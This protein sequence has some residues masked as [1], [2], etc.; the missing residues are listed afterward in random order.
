MGERRLIEGAHGQLEVE[1]AGPADGVALLFHTGTPADG[2]IYASQVREGAERGLRHVAY[3]RPGYGRSARHADRSVADCV[4]DVV[5]IAD[6]LGIGRFFTAGLSGGGPHALACAAELSDRVIAAATL[7]GI[8]PFDA[9]GLDWWNGM[10]QENLDEMG[11]AAVGEAELRA[12]LDLEGAQLAAVT[13]PELNAAFGDLVSQ[14][15]RDALTGEFAEFMA[16]GVRE[17]LAPGVDGWLDDDLAFVRDWGFDLASIRVP[18]TVWQGE[19]D[20][21]VPL[22]H[23]AWLAANV[24]SAKARLEPDHGHLS[25]VLTAYGEI[26]DELIAAAD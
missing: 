14:P 12:Y 10:G 20:R 8:A 18:V 5:A 23:G 3:S 17:A 11:A 1:S 9:Q 13:G 2:T 26:L 25:L 4:T 24:P 19:Q 15:D 22:A 6:A 16:A 7:G 21:F